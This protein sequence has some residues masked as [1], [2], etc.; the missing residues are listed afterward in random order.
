MG[1]QENGSIGNSIDSRGF[2]ISREGGLKQN[3]YPGRV[4]QI[5]NENSSSHSHSNSN[6]PSLSRTTDQG[7]QTSYLV[8]NNIGTYGSISH[9]NNNYSSGSGVV[10]Q[11]IKNPQQ[12][13]QNTINCQ[14]Y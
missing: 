7:Y 4:G 9:Q 6:E 11:N 10:Y 12:S 3:F 1:V 14:R 8:K 5:F 13:Y 2:K